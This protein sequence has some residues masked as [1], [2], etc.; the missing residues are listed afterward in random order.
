MTWPCKF[1]YSIYIEYLILCF[2]CELVNV[3]RTQ[4]LEVRYPMI[5][6]SNQLSKSTFLS[7]C[8]CTWT[9][10][11]YQSIPICVVCQFRDFLLDLWQHCSWSWTE[12][13]TV[14]SWPYLITSSAPIMI[15]ECH[16]FVVCQ[17]HG[18]LLDMLT[19]MSHLHS[20]VCMNEVF[21]T[22]W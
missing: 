14:K 15:S 9:N 7:A 11:Y 5:W 19:F 18:F 6:R 21:V 20:L 16:L 10:S 4:D 2:H 8:L 12:T 22:F 1:S 3:V 17:L 13:E